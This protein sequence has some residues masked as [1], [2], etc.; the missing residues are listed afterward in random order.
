ML[1]MTVKDWTELHAQCSNPLVFTQNDTLQPMIV[2]KN[3]PQDNIGF[4]GRPVMGKILILPVTAACK[5]NHDKPWAC[6]SVSEDEVISQGIAKVM[7]SENRV[8]LLSLA[9]H[10]IWLE[11]HTHLGEG[12]NLM[13]QKHAAQVVAFVEQVWDNVEL[14]MIHCHAGISRSS[15]IGKA[16]SE[17]YEDQF[18]SYYSK[19]YRP[20]P[21]VYKLVQEQFNGN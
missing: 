3:L 9:F 20:N 1:T 17:K 2:P 7:P 11:K 18:H 21:H 16:I 5:F 14:L 6:I 10:D 19:L 12:Y 8:G 4:L 15:A 13:E